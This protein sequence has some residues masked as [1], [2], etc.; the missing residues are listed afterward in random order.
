MDEMRIV[1]LGK[2]GVGKSSVANTILGENVFQIGD[3]ANSET[4]ECQSVTR[5]VDGRDLTLID[6]PG[7]FDTHRPEEEM[8]AE[9]VR[10]ITECSP[11]P[12]A[13]IIVFKVESFT[14]Q[15]QAVIDKINEYFSEESFKY[16]TVL[17]TRGDDLDEGQTIEEFFNNN[18]LVRD[19]M[20]KCGGRCHVVDTEDWKNNQQDEYRS[21]QFQVK[22][23][24]KTIDHM[25]K[26]NKGTCFTNEVLQA[27]EELRKEEEEKIRQSPG[28][29]TEE[30]IREEGK[31]SLYKKLLIR[32]AGFTTGALLGALFGGILVVVG[33]AGLAG[34]T[35]GSM[36]GV[37]ALAGAIKGGF[38]G[39]DA[40]GEA[41][42]VG[43]AAVRAGN[44]VYK[45]FTSVFK[46]QKNAALNKSE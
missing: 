25:M 15:E 37:A 11:G 29:M 10:C 38:T 19:L 13:F 1:I 6:T 12:H 42:T 16:A 43:E 36:I 28:N 33:T 39:Y 8:K 34:A 22:Q 21:N 9:I 41:D 4:S 44:A 5:R 23:L 3:T 45:G 26:A 2:T 30:E 46:N 31:K 14:Y 18:H 27:V 17:F 20:K 35:A 7:W 40:A 32:L 24:L